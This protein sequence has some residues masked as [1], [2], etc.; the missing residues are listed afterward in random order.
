MGYATAILKFTLALGSLQ[1][2]SP[3][4]AQENLARGKSFATV[5]ECLLKSGWR[6]VRTNLTLSDG[7]PE[8]NFGDAA[9]FYSAGITE[10]QACSGTGRN[11]CLFNYRRNGIC[12]QLGTIGEYGV[13]TGPI[14]EK[15]DNKC[16]T[17]K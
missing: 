1:F 11:Y 4:V 3:A 10:V 7:T 13:G 14:L 8:N 12:L 6:P 2:F 16:Q 15:W 9:L 17:A 5:R